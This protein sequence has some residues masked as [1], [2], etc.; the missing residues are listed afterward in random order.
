VNWLSASAIAALRQERDALRHDIERHVAICAEQAT[1][2]ETLRHD[3]ASARIKVEALRA[4]LDRTTGLLSHANIASG[5]C[6]CGDSME[7][8]AT[9]YVCGHEKLDMAQ[10]SADILVRDIKA[11]LHREET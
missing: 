3:R 6:C 9:A 11:A 5:C 1:E 10:Y 8:H 2:M 4:L 7:S